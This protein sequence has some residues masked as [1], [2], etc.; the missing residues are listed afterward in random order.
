M[1]QGFIPADQP[2][3]QTPDS[4]GFVPADSPVSTIEAPPKPTMAGIESGAENFQDPI[5]NYLREAENLTEEG[6]KQHPIE[7]VVGQGVKRTQG[8]GRLIA[9]MANLFMGPE[10][11]PNPK[12][13]MSA[14][15]VKAAGIQTTP[16]KISTPPEPQPMT[17]GQAAGARTFQNRKYNPRDFFPTHATDP[18]TRP[19]G[20]FGST[21]PAI[22]TEPKVEVPTT[23]PVVGPKSIASSN[24]EIMKRY[25]AQGIRG[26]TAA[27]GQQLKAA[28]IRFDR[29]TKGWILPNTESGGIKIE[30]GTEPP[31]PEGTPESHVWNPKG[32]NGPGWYKSGS[33]GAKIVDE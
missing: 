4:A 21:A 13:F 33:A 20:S 28:G 30:G 6:K 31:R 22:P 24:E 10:G 26:I 1:P 27:E 29:V 19:P 3:V 23:E 15:D 11:M 18:A 17:E 2:I 5:H 8:F 14:S 12:P 25:D 7:N 9:P 32:P 16:F